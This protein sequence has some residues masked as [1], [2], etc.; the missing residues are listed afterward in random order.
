MTVEGTLFHSHTGDGEDSA[1]DTA[2]DKTTVCAPSVLLV[3]PIYQVF[4][5]ICPLYELVSEGIF[6]H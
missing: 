6:L 3:A 4:N 2:F 1:A 5:R